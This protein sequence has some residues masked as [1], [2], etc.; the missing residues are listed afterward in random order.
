MRRYTDKLA[1][2]FSKGFMEEFTEDLFDFEQEYIQTEINGGLLS[3][4]II[5]T[6]Q[7]LLQAKST[8]S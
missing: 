4:R 5:T 7:D 6:H 3:N 2:E 1:R 8:S